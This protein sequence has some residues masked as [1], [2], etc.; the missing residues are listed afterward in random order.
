[1]A[2]P[3]FV[4][5][6]PFWEADH[7]AAEAERRTG[8]QMS[9]SQVS[10]Y[11]FNEG[12]SFLINNRAAGAKLMLRKLQLL[13]NNYEIPDNYSFSFMRSHFMPVLKIPFVGFGILLG[14]AI[15][16]MWFAWW[17]K[18]FS[19][20]LILFAAVYS[21][22]LLMFY[23]VSRYRVPLVPVVVLFASFY[24]IK[25]ID[26]WKLKKFGR[27]FLPICVVVLMCFLAFIPNSLS[28]QLKAKDDAQYL[29]ITGIVLLD[30]KKYQEAL[31][32]L[33]L[34]AQKFVDPHTLY[35][36]GLV[37]EGIGRP[38]LAFRAYSYA[39]KLHPGEQLIRKRL[40]ELR[41]SF[42]S[43]R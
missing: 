6:G 33:T 14:L 2:M 17:E 31:Q 42:P 22:S 1:M 9:P 19:R 36:L 8:H 20:P 32:Y 40:E 30:Q 13:V 43:S 24:I 18:Y 11:W 12:I 41:K 5:P 34:S 38:D 37:Y 26:D 21:L 25:F 15:A 3:Y 4:R 7:F 27:H 35:N 23:V 39:L 16:G 28:K 10:R 29:K